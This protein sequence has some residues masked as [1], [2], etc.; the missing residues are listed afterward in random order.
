M[1]NEGEPGTRARHQ[2]A[3][4]RELRSLNS[5]PHTPRPRKAKGGVALGWGVTDRL[6]VI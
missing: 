3:G 1:V 5:P 6:A 2:G 4:S